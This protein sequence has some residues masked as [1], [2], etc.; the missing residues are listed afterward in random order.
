MTRGIW[1]DN[2]RY[3]ET[4]WSRFPG[5]WYHGDWASVDED[6]FWFLHGRADE[7]MNVAGRKV[8]P[9]EV[10]EAMMQH[11]GVA[12][13]AV[14]GAPDEIK[15]EAIVGYAVAKPDAGARPCRHL[16]NRGAGSGTGLQA[17][18]GVDCARA[19]QDTE[20]QDCAAP[21]AAEISRRGAGRSLHRGEPLEP[22]RQIKS[23]RLITRLQQLIASRIR[24]KIT[25]G[26]MLFT[27]AIVIVGAAAVFTG[28]NPLFLIV[29]AMMATLLV[30]GFVSRLCLAGLELDFIVPEH[31]AA[32]RV[33]PGRLYV[34][35]RKWFM[36]SFSTRV[37]AVQERESPT[38]ESSVY[39]PL[40]A[41]G[42][43]LDETVEVRFPRRGSYERN[44]FAFST[45]FPFGFLEVRHASR[46]CEKPWFIPPSIR[47][48]GSKSC[49]A[50]S[51]AIS[52][53]TTRVSAGTSTAS[54][55]M[56][57]LRA[58]AL[59]IGRLPPMPAACRCANSRANRSKLSKCSLTAAS[60][61]IS[62]PGSNTQSIVAPSSSGG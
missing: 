43:T 20:R 59:S 15:G 30:S 13:A 54:A 58:R 17:A 23:T 36:P 38:L 27:A 14:I 2:E 41:A 35:N 46:C 47:N 33:A 50:E 5:M 12:E 25:R 24:Y 62:T 52:K 9:A 39:F 32:T 48:R 10:E 56:R 51:R 16:R 60:R 37:T 7:S 8:G 6:G 45:S 28:D 26:G 18:R 57:P 3:I 21:V 42:V 49:W 11:P 19:S 4:Y 40:I 61:T 29:A 44:T 1:N 22:Y 34:R 55:P 53:P 31:V